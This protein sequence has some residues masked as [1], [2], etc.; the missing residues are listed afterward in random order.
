MRPFLRSGG[1]TGGRIRETTNSVI[2]SEHYGLLRSP[3]HAAPDENP[4]AICQV[5]RLGI[6]EISVGTRAKMRAAADSSTIRCRSNTSVKTL[7]TTSLFSASAS[8]IA[9][10]N[11]RCR[12]SAI[13]AACQRPREAALL[14]QAHF[15]GA[16][17][18]A[19]IRLSCQS[20]TSY[21]PTTRSA[22]SIAPASSAQ[23]RSTPDLMRPSGPI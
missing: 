11:A 1:E 2:D 21:S 13:S 6:R 14:V 10:P 12:S 17:S 3:A 19:I 23:S 15:F 8:G 20:S 16:S 5:D 7:Q 18:R 22:A 9:A 4:R